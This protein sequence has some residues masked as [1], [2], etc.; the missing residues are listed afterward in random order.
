V[1]DGETYLFP[2]SGAQ[3]ITCSISAGEVD[4]TINR[5]GRDNLQLAV[6]MRDG[7]DD[8][9]GSVFIITPDG[10]FSVTL[11]G[12]AEGFLIDGDTVTY[13]GPI[14]TDGGEQVEASVS[15]T[16]P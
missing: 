10:N 15:V 7:P 1:V 13:E 11:S 2:A 9:I 16:C 14:E 12:E 5:L 3:S 8:W 6:D 4:I